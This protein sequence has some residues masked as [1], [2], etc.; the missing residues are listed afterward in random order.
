METEIVKN[1]LSAEIIE[2]IVTK[3]DLSGLSIQQK[4]TYLKYTCD[5]LSLDPAAQPFNLISFKQGSFFKEVLYCTKA[6]AEQ[7]NNNNNVSH[8]IIEE[9]EE[10]GLYIVKARASLPNG[11]FVEDVGI[12]DVSKGFTGGVPLG[13]ELA[14]LMLKAVT[15]AKRRATL[16]LLGLGM[17]DETEVETLSDVKVIDIAKKDTSPKETNGSGNAPSQDTRTFCQREGCGKIV[18]SPFVIAKSMERFGKVYCFP[19]CQNIMEK[20]KREEAEF[21]VPELDEVI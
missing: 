21:S 8:Q 11:R 9:K 13:I 2:K 16:S 7:L 4:L 5:K 18:K 3:G 6:G 15:K 12:V 20:Q 10:K 14:N 17:M 1:E 19:E